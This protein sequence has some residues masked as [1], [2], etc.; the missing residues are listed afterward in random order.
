MELHVT[1]HKAAYIHVGR[2][3]LGGKPLTFAKGT[4]HVT[5]SKDVELVLANETMQGYAK[6]GAVTIEQIEPKPA[7]KAKRK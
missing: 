4:T 7:P 3:K 2:G 1:V 6:S 5:D